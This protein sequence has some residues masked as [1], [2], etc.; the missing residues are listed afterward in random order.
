[1]WLVLATNKF[2]DVNTMLYYAHHVTRC[3]G[4]IICMIPG[5]HRIYDRFNISGYHPDVM[6]LLH[7]CMFVLTRV[8]R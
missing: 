4:V 6:Q 5:L 2:K 1:M 3:T 7:E 8:L